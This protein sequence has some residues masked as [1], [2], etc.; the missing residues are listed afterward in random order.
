MK[1]KL[2]TGYV[3]IVCLLLVVL[4]ILPLSVV[5]SQTKVNS[6]VIEKENS[7]QQ[8]WQ[9]SGNII[10]ETETPVLG[11]TIFDKESGNGTI[12]NINGE[13][14]I[15]VTKG[16]VLVITYVGYQ[17]EEIIIQNER[18]INVRLTEESK[19]LDEIV[20]IGY[21]QMKRSD[22][23]GSLATI[24]IDENEA[25]QSSSVDRLLQGKSAG[26]DVISGNGAPGGVIS[27]KVRGVSTLTGNS[28]PLYVV[29]GVIM[30]T[31]SQDVITQN[32]VNYVQE[33]QNGLT[34]IDPQDIE[35]MEVLKDASATAIYGSRGANGVVLI[36]TKTGSSQ[37]GKIR[38]NITNDV[39]W[40]SKKIPML[41]GEEFVKFENEFTNM[42][43][44]PL[45]QT[46]TAG[47]S[48]SLRTIDWQDYAL[49]T[50]FNQQIRLSLSNQTK[51]SS[52]YV[53]GGF[54]SYEGIIKNSGLSK[55]N[56]RVNLSQDINEKLKVNSN[57]GLNYVY[58][59]WVQ[60]SDRLGQA[61][62]SMIRSMLRKSPVI[63]YINNDDDSEEFLSTESPKTWF[64]Q[65]EDVSEEFRST[66]SLSFDYAISSHLSYQLALGGD[67]R[68]KERRQFW[69]PGL[70]SGSMSNGK[71]TLS[72]LKYY[73]Y[74]IQNLIF[75]NKTFGHNSISGTLGFTYDK[76]STVNTANMTQNFFTT[77]LG[78][79]GVSLG[80]I[81]FVPVYDIIDIAVV[82]SLFRLNYS[83]HDKYI[84]TVTARYDGSSKFAE[85]HKFGFFPSFAVAWRASEEDFI[86]KL[87]VFSNLKLRLSWGQSGVQT[88]SPYATM[89]EFNSVQYPDYNKELQTGL[90]RGRLTND[91][92]TWETSEQ[93]NVGLDLGFWHNRV[94]V[95]LD[96]Y[97]KRSINLLQ[98]FRVPPSSGFSTMA[99]NFGTIRNRGV[100]FMVDALLVSKKNV[101]WSIGGNVSF[102]RNKLLNI[103]LQPARWGM[104]EMIAYTGASIANQTMQVPANIFAED[105]PVAMFWGY[106]TKGIFQL[107]DKEN[108]MYNGSLIKP[109]EIYYADLNEDGKIDDQ[110]K[111]FIGD[112]NPGITYGINTGIKYKRFK[113]DINF[114]GV[115]DRDIAN[116]N[117][118][119]EEYARG[120]GLNIRREAYYDAWRPDN[121][122]NTYTRLGIDY[123][124]DFS[125]RFIEDGSYLR[126]SNVSLTWN[127]PVK[128]TG[129]FN[130]MSVSVSGRNLFIITNYKGF[131]PDVNSFTFNGSLVGVDFNSYPNSSS[132]TI[133]LNV[134]F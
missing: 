117:L 94:N 106:Q 98:N 19:S 92:L 10:D 3:P 34:S 120:K 1:I 40:I 22:I 42:M 116:I 4:T 26:V 109:G 21:G 65:F 5:K 134:G 110:D 47:L 64:E 78:A 113:L 63:G 58:N 27:V 91:H 107:T 38:V 62:S 72:T 124:A 119:Y 57:I 82:S 105:Y 45:K 39:A 43:S 133:G 87:R 56:L 55:G 2:L 46:Y 6:S 81:S 88:I 44:P 79:N 12:S 102:N 123:P 67:F 103:G 48:D 18:L 32:S 114:T 49:R 121:P 122:S 41:S 125:D 130:S 76:N 52:Y 20:V 75:Y 131:D 33:S 30:N 31:A 77:T 8:S 37:Q 99:M 29:D 95:N 59:N 68:H 36:K 112:P 101:K 24:K 127:V 61:N 71:A 50:A 85:N 132:A 118:L 74:D 7:L 17:K 16:T 126:L 11:A 35:S 51:N 129:I 90:V 70:Y 86:K 89:P 111:T 73:M 93:Y 108:V 104:S 13:F 128:R 97:S 53:A 15:K 25:A 28:E 14:N 69:G 9:L 84:A 23:T 54:S 80:A 83:L 115:Y 60:G 100:E 96:M 66:V